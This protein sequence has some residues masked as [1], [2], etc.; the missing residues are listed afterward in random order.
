MKNRVR[1]DQCDEVLEFVRR[2]PGC[3]AQEVGDALYPWPDTHE[4]Y[5]LRRPRTTR[6]AFAE[7]RLM[8]LLEAGEVV[9][10]AVGSPATWRASLGDREK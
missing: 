6:K 9:R 10:D 3:T 2:R 8:T 5:T 4:G 1:R 7:R